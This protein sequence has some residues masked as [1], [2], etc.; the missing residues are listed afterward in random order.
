MRTKRLISR[1]ATVRRIVAVVS[2]AATLAVA[3]AATAAASS[4]APSASPFGAGVFPNGKYGES[5]N[6]KA[7]T[8]A[9]A[10]VSVKALPT[11]AM[12]KNVVLAAMKRAEQKVDLDLAY[13]CWKQ[14]SCDTGTGGKLVLGDADG[15]CGNVWRKVTEMEIILQ[16]LTYKEIGKIIYTCAN[17]D[18]Q[19]A[20]SDFRGLISQGANVMVGYADAGN[21][22]LPAVRDATKRN[23]PFSTYVGGIIGTPGK[24]YTTVL[25]QDLCGLGK[26]FAAIVNKA[27][28]GGSVAFLGGTPGNTLTPQWQKCEKAALSKNVKYVGSADTSW[29]REGALKATS[30]FI[31]KFSDLK[32][33]SFEYADGFVGALQAYEAA[34]KAPDIVYTGSTDENSVFCEAKKVGNKN[35]KIWSGS[36]FNSQARMAV[37]ANMM[38]LAGAKIPGKIVIKPILVESKYPNYGCRADLPIE[39]SPRAAVPLSLFKRMFP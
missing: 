34:H 2:L 10:I 20:I 37:T 16:A 39:A 5:Y 26:Q 21:A 35:F 3:V 23:I 27:A 31:S 19:K 32:A 25:T 4:S 13:K 17:F 8:V 7:A 6:P 30:A 33:I 29:T 12:G 1:G 38:K 36:G 15:F 11:D 24:D 18:T 14:G 9:K 28:A 22:L